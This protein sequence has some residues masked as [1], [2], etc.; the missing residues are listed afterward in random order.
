MTAD[1]LHELN[2]LLVFTKR[3]NGG[4]QSVDCNNICFTELMH[5]EFITPLG[6]TVGVHP[7]KIAIKRSYNY[8]IVS[9]NCTI[10]KLPSGTSWAKLIV[11]C[12][13]ESGQV[14][15]LRILN[16]ILSIITVGSIVL[17]IPHQTI[18]DL[19]EYYM[20]NRLIGD[21]GCTQI[22]QEYAN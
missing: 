16:S 19:T 7:F 8:D 10:V 22:K 9:G 5:E 12:T 13:L 11:I 17:A 2:H 4:Y 1:E 6:R 15:R 14:L 3:P 20:L 18:D 21:V